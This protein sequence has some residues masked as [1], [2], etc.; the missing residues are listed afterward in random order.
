MKVLGVALLMLLGFA[1]AGDAQARG[2]GMAGCGGGSMIMG[3]HGGQIS[4]ASSN[5]TSYQSFALSTGT[6]NC[7]P[8]KDMSM[9]ERRF[10]NHN[11]VVFEK[12][13]AQGEGSTIVAL[14]EILGCQSNSQNA[15][16][17][18]LK[19]SYQSIFAEPGAIAVMIETKNQL[20]KHPQIVKSCTK[21]S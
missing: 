16:N 4:A 1:Q 21:L 20:R 19:N 17:K 2:Y 13:V 14:S 7:V 12:E 18:A 8:D 9:A 6:S 11:L 3:P 15:I 5:A 10:I